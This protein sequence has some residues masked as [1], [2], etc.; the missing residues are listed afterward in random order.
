MVLRK[1][2][3]GLSAK[4]VPNILHAKFM[5]IVPPGS[6]GQPSLRSPPLALK[7][8]DAGFLFLTF[9]DRPL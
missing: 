9:R 4:E 2:C 7:T 3:V 6:M 5:Q 8:F 1:G